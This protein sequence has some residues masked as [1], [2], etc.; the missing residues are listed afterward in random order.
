MS[1]AEI[2]ASAESHLAEPRNMILSTIRRDGRPQLAP[3]WFI[4]RDGEFLISTTPTTAKWKNLQR[5]P[6]C[7]GL[8]DYPG[9]KY[10]SVT[11]V[12]EMWEE[13][14]PHEITSEIVRKYVESERYEAYMEMIRSDRPVRGIIRLNPEHI[15]ASGFE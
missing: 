2:P 10:I 5:D 15:I 11:G 12:A 7:T 14:V 6:R 1:F 13:N 3:V 9:G 8:V 4:W